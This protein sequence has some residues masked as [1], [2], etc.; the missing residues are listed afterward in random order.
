VISDLEIWRAANLLLKR[1]GEKA[2]AEVRLALM[3]LQLPAIARVRLS[4]AG[5]R[6]PS[7]NSP[8]KHRP[9]CALTGL[10]T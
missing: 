1:Y 4:G 10:S 9:A 6:M 8:T 7:C 5:S 3:R 2:G